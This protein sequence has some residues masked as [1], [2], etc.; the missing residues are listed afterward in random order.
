VKRKQVLLDDNFDAIF[1]RVKLRHR[2]VSDTVLLR[3]G[4]LALLGMDVSE[5]DDLC[6]EA[7]IAVGKPRKT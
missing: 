6:T 1:E 7:Y 5:A 2:R 3:A 4:I